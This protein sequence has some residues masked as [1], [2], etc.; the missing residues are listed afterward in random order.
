MISEK[1][2]KLSMEHWIEIKPEIWERKCN[3][4]DLWMGPFKEKDGR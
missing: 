3:I 2:N 1:K 4:L